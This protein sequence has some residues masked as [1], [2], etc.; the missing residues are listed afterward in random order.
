M[1]INTQGDHVEIVI[2]NSQMLIGDKEQRETKGTPTFADRRSAYHGWV[3]ATSTPQIQCIAADKDE[4]SPELPGQ[5]PVR[6]A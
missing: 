3:L 2:S 4:L 6:D 1:T 5:P